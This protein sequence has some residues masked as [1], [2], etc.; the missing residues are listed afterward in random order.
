MK[1]YNGAIAGD[2]PSSFPLPLCPLS[3]LKLRPNPFQI[4]LPA[5]DPNGIP[6][7]TVLEA[8]QLKGMKTGL[9]ATSRITHATPASFASHVLW[10]DSENDIAVQEVDQ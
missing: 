4:L 8:A 5:V 7:P 2:F 10:R 3:P 9:V 6:C 1:S